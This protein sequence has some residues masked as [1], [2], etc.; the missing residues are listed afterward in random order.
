MPDFRQLE[1]GP[2]STGATDVSDVLSV[3][4][5]LSG[6]K[7]VELTGYLRVPVT[8]EYQ[9]YL[10]TDSNEGSRAFVHL[11]DMQLI[12]AD[13]AYTPGTQAAS[14][15]REGVSGDVQ[16]NAVQTVK[17][18][19]GLHPIRIGYVGKAASSSLSLQWEGPETSGREPV[20]ASAFSYEYVNP[21][22]LEKTEETVGCAASGTGLTVQTHL[23]WTVSC[24]QPW[25]TVSPFPVPEP[26]C[27][28]LPWKQTGCKR[29]GKPLSPSYAAGS[30]GHSRCA[31]K[32]LLPR[33]GTTSGSRTILRMGRRMSK[34]P[35]MPAPPE[36]EF[37]I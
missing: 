18:T 20:P 26:Q 15:A 27:W 24:D 16:P 21:F 5:G 36:T 11:H 9:F 14:N 35:R 6:Q 28:I 17:L 2:C 8:G 25:V 19:A 31:R 22:N 7:G 30:R 1:E 32:L 23:P 29:S 33:Q 37:P 13:Y 12:D 4:A 34:W 3:K 10:Q